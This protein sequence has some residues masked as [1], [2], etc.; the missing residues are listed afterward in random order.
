MYIRGENQTEKVLLDT[1]I[2]PGGLP[3]SDW[4]K[5]GFAIFVMDP[6]GQVYV[7][8]HDVGKF[9]HSSFLG[10]EPVAA[11]GEM[12]VKNGIIETVSNK[13]GHYRP[14]PE[15]MMNLTQKLQSD[16]VD[17]TNLKVKDRVSTQYYGG[18]AAPAP[19]YGAN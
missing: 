15:Q 7:G 16:G 1:T 8:R 18:Y 14:G 4:S 2:K 17:T 12:I 10:G 3:D 11:A 6:E 9:H 13:S 5:E 19:S